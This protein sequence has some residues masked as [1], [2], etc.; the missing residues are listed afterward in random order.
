MQMVLRFASCDTC[1]HYVHGLSFEV[2]SWRVRSTAHR[3]MPL[4][5]IL[6]TNYGHNALITS[7]ALEKRYCRICQDDSG[8]FGEDARMVQLHKTLDWVGTIFD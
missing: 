8:T 3:I 4:Q 1:M 5:S 6:S 2:H 7:F